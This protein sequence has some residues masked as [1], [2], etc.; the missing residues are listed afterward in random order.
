MIATAKSITHDWFYY[1]SV[2]TGIAAT[3]VGVWYRFVR[4]ERQRHDKEKELAAQRRRESDTFMFGGTTNDGE[5][6][7]SAPRR[8]RALELTVA[9]VVSSNQKVVSGLSVVEQ[10]MDEANGTARKTLEMVQK[11]AGQPPASV[12]EVK[13]VMV[14]EQAGIDA[15]QTALL[16]AI[17]KKDKE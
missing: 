5:E 14:E 6:I 17:A 16:D 7:I 8:M 4:P 11:I 1:I 13:A 9:A 2:V 12:A 15:R 3:W 10:R